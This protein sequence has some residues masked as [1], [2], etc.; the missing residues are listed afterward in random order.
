MAGISTKVTSQP[1]GRKGV[2]E[3]EF[4]MEGTAYAKA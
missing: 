2:W 1:K 3:K 4:Q